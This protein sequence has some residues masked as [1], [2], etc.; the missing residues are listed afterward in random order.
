MV[1][2]FRLG[3]IPVRVQ[4]WFFVLVVIL[5][6]P[7]DIAGRDRLVQ[8][9]AWVAIVFGSVMAHELGHAMMGRAFGLAP[10]IELHG[11]GGT[12]SWSAAR[13]PLSRLQRIAISL[14]GPFAG[15]LVGGLVLVAVRAGVVP[16]GEGWDR[17]VQRLLF[18]NLGWG[19]FNLLP[20]LPLDGGNVSL[21]VWNG[22]TKGQGERPARIVSIVVMALVAVLAYGSLGWWGA[23]LAL[24]FIGLN[25][26]AL[27]RLRPG[28]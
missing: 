27:Q 26:Q 9:L 3:S 6:S 16:P 10:S 23:L 17:A 28:L 18:V 13:R 21:E 19:V 25:V 24:S 7:G 22:L 12:T 4:P 11:M 14:A 15:F 5:G 2:S 20:V 1:L 8:L